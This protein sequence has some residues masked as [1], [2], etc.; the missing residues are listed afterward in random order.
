M[1]K[2]CSIVVWLGFGTP[3]AALT[4][5]DALRELKLGQATPFATVAALGAFGNPAETMAFYVYWDKPYGVANRRRGFAARR[6]SAPPNL[7]LG[8]F[9]GNGNWPCFLSRVPPHPQGSISYG[10]VGLD[11]EQRSVAGGELCLIT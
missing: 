6:E 8:D 11:A 9:L 7:P 1:R 4:T 3:A 5:G 2:F 10:R